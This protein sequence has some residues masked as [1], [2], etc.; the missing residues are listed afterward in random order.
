MN[1]KGNKAVWTSVGVGVV[2]AAGAI[3]N[4][5]TIPNSFTPH[6]PALA[7]Q[8]NENFLAVKTSVDDNAARISS[9]EAKTP[10]IYKRAALML[11]PCSSTSGSQTTTADVALFTAPASGIVEVDYSLTRLHIFFPSPVV[12]SLKWSP[13]LNGTAGNTEWI[14]ESNDSTTTW[15]T[16][17]RSAKTVFA[18][19]SGQSVAMRMTLFTELHCS[20]GQSGGTSADLDGSMIVRFWPGASLE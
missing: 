9:L 17:T 19:T 10:H 7:A 15:Q 2:I 4:T 14:F 12:A 5:L 13:V 18:V 3:A 1:F 6:T 11:V 8:V 20:A 16:E